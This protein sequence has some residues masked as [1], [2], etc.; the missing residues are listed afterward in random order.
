MGASMSRKRSSLFT[1]RKRFFLNPISTSHTSYI[2]VEAESSR[3]GEYSY[4]NY[5]LT[6]ADCRRIVRLEFLLSTKQYRRMSL[7]KLDLLINVLTAFRDAIQKEIA[8]IE[9]GPR[10]GPTKASK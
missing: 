8:L 4:G 6:L 1:F 5:L 9:R 2:Y 7:K 3:D 10:R